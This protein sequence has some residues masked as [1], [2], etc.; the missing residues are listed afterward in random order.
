MRHVCPWI[1][2]FLLVAAV[3]GH[4]IS[5]ASDGTSNSADDRPKAGP[6]DKPKKKPQTLAVHGLVIDA[7]TKQAIP[8]FRVIP[9]ALQRYGVTWQ[10]HLITT[11][12]GGRFDF[13]PDVRAWPR[14]RYRVEAEGHRPS[15]SR[16]VEKSEGD[17]KLTFVMQADAG[18]SAVVRTPGRRPGG[19]KRKWPGRQVLP[20]GD[21]PRGDDHPRR[22][23]TK[24][25]GAT[26]SSPPTPRAGSG[27]RPRATRARII[28]AHDRGYRRRAAT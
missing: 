28:D 17:V 12:R 2:I 24:V 1:L 15:V 21:R 14:T 13:L 20:R 19:Q 18:I 10:L 26:G 22:A 8:R 27:Y 23:R 3:N 16:I 7:T 4:R 5:K 25:L 9:G 6:V 11:H